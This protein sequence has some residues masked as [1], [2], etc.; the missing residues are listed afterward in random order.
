M[1]DKKT[2]DL[3]LS[4]KFKKQCK[5]RRQE[6]LYRKGKKQG[7]KYT[8][9]INRQGNTVSGSTIRKLMEKLD[10]KKQREKTET[11]EK[12]RREAI[13]RKIKSLR[14]RYYN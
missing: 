10:D 5:K 14:K 3:M 4:A 13:L 7:G 1:I 12:L 8:H 11:L 6:D 2:N 9:D